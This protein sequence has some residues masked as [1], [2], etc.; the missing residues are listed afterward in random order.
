MYPLCVG[1]GPH[2]TGDGT[3]RL[4]IMAAS[5][6]PPIISVV[7][8]CLGH[9]RELAYCLQALEAQEGS[10]TF[11]VIVVDSASD[12]AVEAVT[13]GFP[14]ARLVRSGAGLSTGAARNAGASAASADI[15]AFIDADC[16]PEH[17]WIRAAA[18]CVHEGAA[19]AS[20]PI[21]DV[22]PWHFIAA[23][24]NRLQF[25]DFPPRRPAG[26][27]PYLPGAHLAMPR[28]VLD[29]VGGFNTEAIVSQ[30]IL[31]T[32]PVA[33]ENP[34]KVRFC[35]GMSV[36]HWGRSTW[37]EFL[38]H[39]RAFGYSRAAQKLRMNASLAWLGEHPILAGLVL[40]RR[41]AYIA[42]RV[43]QWNLPDLPRFILQLP[44]LLI[45]LTAW[46]RGFY[47]GMRASR[48]SA[49]ASTE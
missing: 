17:G 3:L 23:S 19:L 31:L 6:N 42:L 41:L 28:T 27:H 5:V 29:A 24:D 1:R 7:I 34:D 18:G 16:I 13:R 36:R 4:E 40:M 43:L 45:G 10:P 20:G 44:V 37:G 14:R 47:E 26:T 21:M 25:V 11:E 22:R 12:P 39:Q 30:D 2:E 38:E 9:A 46:T 8:P 49:D 15:L 33:S 48:S 32:E 35:P